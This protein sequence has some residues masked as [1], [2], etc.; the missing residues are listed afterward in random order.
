MVDRGAKNQTDRRFE[1]ELDYVFARGTLFNSFA[2]S[3]STSL[4]AFHCY[5]FEKL[6]HF[7]D[8]SQYAA[9]NIA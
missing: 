1:R 9:T 8:V 3:F 5:R 7:Y 2:A 6:R 4:N